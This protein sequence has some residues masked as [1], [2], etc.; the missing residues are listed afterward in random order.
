MPNII[1]KGFAI[2]LPEEHGLNLG[3]PYI[4]CLLCGA[5]FQGPLDIR[6]PAG[7][8]PHNSLIALLAQT[9]RKEWAE[10]HNKKNHT[11]KEK[12][13]LTLSGNFATPLAAQKLAAKGIFSIIDLVM[14][15]EVAAALAEAPRMPTDETE[16]KTYRSGR[17]F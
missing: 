1:A 8:E 10:R 7:H 15:N 12:I 3:Y 16:H 17:G 6:V 9:K 4:A 14:D 11:E 13:D 2:G 5:V